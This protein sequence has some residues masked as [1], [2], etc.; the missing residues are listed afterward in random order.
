MKKRLIAMLL[1]ISVILSVVP[2]IVIAAGADDVTITVVDKDGGNI[3]ESGLSVK[4]TH[5]YGTY[6]TRTQNVTVTNSG[7]GVFVFDGSRYDRTDTKYYTVAAT[8]QVDGRTYS[9]TQQI[10]KNT[11]SVVLTLEDFVQEDKWAVFDVYYVADGHFPE[12]FHGAADAS[13]YGPAG[14]NTPLLSINVNITQLKTYDS[15]VYQE[16]VENSYHFVPDLDLGTLEDLDAE[17]RYEKTLEAASAFWE[18]VKECMDEDS[19]D[20][21]EATGLYDTFVA[22]CLK[23]Q[24]S[25]SKPDNHCDGI[26]SVKPPVYVIEMY[27]HQGHIFGGYTND[28]ETINSDPTDINK[29]LDAYNKHFNQNIEWT[30]NGSG[31]WSG[32]YITTENGRNYK[33]N[34]TIKQTNIK[35]ATGFTSSVGIKYEKKTDTYYLAAFQS[36]TQ[37]RELVDCI[38]TY[39]DGVKD[40]VFNDQVTSLNKGAGI[41]PFEGSTDRENFIFEGWILE[42][43][44][45][46]ILSQQDILKAYPSVTQDMT[47]VAVYTVAPSKYTG[48]VQVILNGSYDSATAT[49]TGQRVDITT[50]TNE[51]ISLY[52]SAD[53]VEYIPLIRQ[54]TGVYSAELLNGT[55]VICYFNGTEYI[56][57]SN[58]YLTINN[59]DRTR[60]IFVNS[61]TYDL[62]GGVGGP[63][64]LTE[65]YL[66]EASVNVT[67]LQPTRAGYLFAGWKDQNGNLYTGGEVL[68]AAIGQAYTLTAQW[69]DAADIYVNVTINHDDGNGHIDP[70]SQKDDIAFDIVFAPNYDTPYLETGDHVELSGNSHAGF[71]MEA[72]EAFTKYT[73]VNPVVADV[74]KE[75]LYSVVASKHNYNLTSVTATTDAAGDIHIEVVLDYAPQNQDLEFEVRV[76][77]VPENLA[78]IA[79]IVKVLAW[80]NETSS[81]KIIAQHLTANGQKHP[82]V[83]VDLNG[84][85]GTGS[86]PVWVN[87]VMSDNT[88]QPYGYRIVV[89]A[90]VYPDGSIIEVNNDL[91]ADLTKNKTD[92]YTI[93][94]GSVADGRVYGDLNGAYFTDG[95]QNGK[96]EAV[97]TTQG[98][99]VIFDATGGK[100]NGFDEQKLE[101]QYK[102]PGFNGFVPV[103]DGGYVFAG[104]YLD[105]ECT[106]A[107]QEDV[108]LKEDV[109]LYAKWKEPLKIEGFLT[110]AGTYEQT[111]QDGSVT[112]QKIHDADLVQQV[113]VILQKIHANGYT[114]TIAEQLVVLD[115]ARTEYYFQGRNV[116]FAEYSFAG[117]PDNLEQYRIQVL[118]PNYTSTFQNES[119]SIDETLKLDYP[120]YNLTDFVAEFGGDKV[121]NVNVHSHFEPKEFDLEYS[122]NAEQIGEGFRPQDVEVLITSDSSNAGVSPDKWTVISQMIFGD[123]M[124]GDF[125]MLQN[126]VA[127]GSDFVWISHPNGVTNYKYGLRVYHIVWEDGSKVQFSDEL[128]FYVQYQAPAYYLGNAQNQELVAI[129][130]PKTFNISYN[131]NG[132]VLDGAYPTT[133]TWSYETSLAGVVPTF[134]GFKFDGW[135]LDENLTIPAGDSIDASV[136][137]DV[138]LYAKWIQIMDVVDLKVTINHAQLGGSG[139]ASNYNKTLYTQLTYVDRNNDSADRVYMD[140][141]DHSRE[142]PSI[143]WH[144]RGDDISIDV[145]EAPKYYTHLSSEYDYGVNVM[146]EGY[147]VSEKTIEKVKQVDGSTLHVVNVTLQYNPDL[148]D[149]EFYVQMADDVPKDAYPESAEVKLLSWY[150]GHDEDTIWEWDRITQHVVTTITV[151]IDPETGYGTGSYPVCHWYDEANSIPYYYRLEVVQLNWADGRSMTLNEVVPAATYSG[152]GYNAEIKVENG[153]L[154]EPSEVEGATT[155][156]GVYA[157]PAGASHVQI[158]SLGAVISVNKVNFHANNS[159]ALG[160]DIFRTYYPAGSLAAGSALYSLNADGTISSFYEIPEFDYETHNKYVFKGWYLDA[161]STDRPLNWND[162]YEGDVDVY[163]H[164]I[165]TGTV[166][167]EA[168]DTKKTSGGTYIGFDLIGIQIREKDAESMAHYGNPASGLRFITVL[169]EELYAQINALSGQTAEYGFV[170]AKAATVTKNIGD[171]AGA[172]LQYKDA[173]V[174]G[175]DTTTEYSFITNMKCSGVDDH[176]DGETY[177]QFTAVITYT[178]SSGEELE[179]QQNE[180]IAARAYLRYYDANGMLRTYYNNYT[181]TN[182]YGGCSASYAIAQALMG[183]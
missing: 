12:S 46:T 83:R 142:Y 45:G 27:D 120:T 165:E 70:S 72:A 10:S 64:P 119:E 61:V 68:T 81:W 3:T 87:E 152:G 67:T 113:M 122:V 183:K 84:N 127:N 24:G 33:Y 171:V 50:V 92:L 150:E 166:E 98:Y 55:Y 115:Y 82:G 48:T 31:V 35:N 149:L 178:Q 38:V 13:D 53:N 22:Y 91:L 76:E 144:N 104:W 26:L 17:E 37:S 156:T 125:L 102:I 173:N 138:V 66:S 43:G 130:I 15:V 42:G 32:S 145:F 36:E 161:D 4:V 34:L 124:I 60:Y 40:L 88:V 151:H 131:L 57:S 133:H 157:E 129:L 123:E 148:V 69:V 172:T 143:F 114:E 49:A 163:A 8:L 59:D 107:G 16:N 21:F 96:L 174:N 94:F 155:L 20:A 106:I 30:D 51:N 181:G 97:I 126:G 73:A 168:D 117:I 139:L 109:T 116:G 93:T 146:M 75:Y 170:I 141:P 44:D 175:V 132:G 80:S 54:S 63:S 18:K 56:P 39:T 19:K 89:T 136:A 74:V 135:Y 29:V 112:I 2:G 169:S 71:N 177:R 101:N 128:P 14:D 154:P 121:A 180:R 77:N 118:I 179:S 5:V 11:N 105:P 78:P 7:G 134:D 86:Y 52:V 9:A 137:E 108:Y 164:W 103:R 162:I 100:V 140:M 159:K 58:Q 65:Y 158:G 79:A 111:N 160:G 25:A 41:V 167:K 182:F 6:F 99:N 110:V 153:S 95:Q 1:A 47:F 23:N 90:I 28:E 85:I 147:Y 62:N 176:Y